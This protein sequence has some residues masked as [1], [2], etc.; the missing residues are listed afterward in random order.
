MTLVVA[1]AASGLL[2]L[3]PG[4]I[5]ASLRDN[6]PLSD[7][8]AG[9]AYR[10]VVLAAVGQALYVGLYLLR[11]ERVQEAR[12]KDAR[13]GRMTRS[14]LLHSVSRNAAALV[15]LTLVYGI[16]AVLITGERS[17]YW[18]FLVLV[19]LQSAGFYR[20]VAGIEHWLAFE[21][22]YLTGRVDRRES[23]G[24][25]D[26]LGPAPGSEPSEV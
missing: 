17:G 9:W 26:S 11:P 3:L 6:R 13:L 4:E 20:R 12:G 14:E 2:A 18:P 23:S 25:H 24:R 21:P 7:P 22:E 10:L 19:L 16:S 8:N 15:G 1:I 5:F